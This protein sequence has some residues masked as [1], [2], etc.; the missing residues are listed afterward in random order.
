MK[1]S[2]SFSNVVTLFRLVLELFLF[3]MDTMWIHL[4]YLGFAVFILNSSVVMKVNRVE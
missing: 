1:D 2:G 4:Q 3:N